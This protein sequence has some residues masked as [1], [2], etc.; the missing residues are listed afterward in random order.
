MIY[1]VTFNPSLDYVAA[2][3]DFQEGIINRTAREALFPGGKGF[4]VSRVLQNLGQDNVAIGFI[5][6]LTGEM[7]RRK[8][9]EYGCRC[10]LIPVKN[11]MSRINLKLRLSKETEINGKGPEIGAEEIEKFYEILDELQTG[12]YLVLA[13]SIPDCLSSDMYQKIMERYQRKGVHFVVDAAG[14]LLKKVL[15]YHPFLIKPNHH[16][17]SE[18][19]HKKIETRKDLIFYGK[20]LQKMGARNVLISRAGEGA[21][22]LTE[23]TELLESPAPKGTVINSVGAGDSMVAGFLAGYLEKGSYEEAFYTGVA[24]GSATAFC[25]DL[26][27]KEDIG[28]VR[29][30]MSVLF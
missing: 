8:M 10:R 5:A 20:E 23:N 21:V 22:L 27:D 28:R 12:D 30:S 16:E 24:A 4:N 6:D 25:E 3:E 18:I 19:F 17:I 13:G 15:P 9:E 11:G 7:I 14:E 2:V 1:T 29:E 26:A